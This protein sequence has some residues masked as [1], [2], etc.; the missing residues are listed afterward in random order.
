MKPEKMRRGDAVEIIYSPTVT[1]HGSI[2]GVG[3]N[4]FQVALE[5]PAEEVTIG[6]PKSWAMLTE[7]GQWQVRLP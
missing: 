5:S 1:L 7:P 6:L 3:W 2:V 4:R